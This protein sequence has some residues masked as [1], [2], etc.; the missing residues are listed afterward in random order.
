MYGF[1]V[2]DLDTEN[3]SALSEETIKTFKKLF[4]DTVLG[5]KLTSYLAD[6]SYSW[7]VILVCSFTAILLGYIYLILIR[8]LGALIIWLSIALLQLSL[9][10]GGVYMYFESNSY[11]ETSDY[12][13]YLK[14][15]AYATWGV[16][17]LFLCCICCC[18]RSIKIG[19]AV[20]ETSAQY[21]A[22]NL[23]I[24]LLPLVAYIV[25]AIWLFTWLVGVVFVFSVGEPT[26]REGYSFI[27]EMKWEDNTRYILLFQLFMLFWINA[28]I[29]GMCQFVIAASA[30]IWYF[31]VNSDTGAHGCVGR[32]IHWG[33]RYHMGSVAFGAALIAIC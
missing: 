29:M 18:W 16:A 19:I 23:R 20:Y 11:E 28:F 21:V 3:V 10:G 27:T 12:R 25:C 1:C 33:F 22:G 7:V 26:A 30:C 13:D 6:I 5:D 9:I 4:N 32:G 15:A 17:G 24:F 31:E 8:Y 2:P 14:Y